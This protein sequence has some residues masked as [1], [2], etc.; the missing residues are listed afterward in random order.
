MGAEHPETTFSAQ[1]MYLSQWDKG[2]GITD[3]DRRQGPK[4]DRKRK[5]GGVRDIFPG[6]TKD[7]L[8]TERRQILAHRQMAVHKGKGG[9]SM[10]G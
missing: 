1:E 3:K 4:K 9:N 5:K 2:Q 6:G 10:L 7:H 8:W